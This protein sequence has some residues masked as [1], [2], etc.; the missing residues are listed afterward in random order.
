MSELVVR[1]RQRVR[2]VNTPLLRRVI[3][4]LL[5]D[6]FGT[7]DYQLC[8]HLV[9]MV[10]MAR[11]NRQFLNHQGSTDVITFCHAGET[12]AQSELH[13]E[14]FVCVDEAVLQARE[15]RATWQ[16][17]IVRY[18]L[19]GILHLRGHDD[20]QAAARRR[21]KREENRRLR[22]LARRF[23]FSKLERAPART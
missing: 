5:A 12:E 13:G 23:S 19:H 3:R 20:K 17:E 4:S 11:V 8:V 21:M 18:I 9:G 14:L 15:F 16:S 6:D 1:N 7:H 22:A 2:R 10:E